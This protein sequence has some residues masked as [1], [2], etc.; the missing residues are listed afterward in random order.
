MHV[1]KSNLKFKTVCIFVTRKL[2][3]NLFFIQFSGN[4]NQFVIRILKNLWC[5]FSLIYVRSR[6][7]ECLFYAGLH[8]FE[9]HA[10]MFSEHFNL[11]EHG[12]WIWVLGEFRF[13]FPL[14]YLFGRLS[15]R[16]DWNMN[17][18]KIHKCLEG[19]LIIF[20]SLKDISPRY[21]SEQAQEQWTKKSSEKI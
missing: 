1:P 15:H 16:F 6:F 21:I 17:R 10:W 13:E 18:K 5:H 4:W 9:E 2:G 7:K 20:I 14:S 8:N 3:K 11:F 12:N 19:T